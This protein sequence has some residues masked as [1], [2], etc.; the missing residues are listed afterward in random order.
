ME[1]DGDDDN[2]D[3]PAAVDKK[4]RRHDV[5]LGRGRTIQ[6]HPGNVYF[7][8]FL[9]QYCDSYDEAPRNQRRKMASELTHAFSAKDIRFLEQTKNGE[10]IESTLENA[11]NKIGQV[12]RN[13]RKKK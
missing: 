3:I 9:K 1:A 12:F 7:R 5:I 8:K 11:E 10:W 4:P 13:L 6:S 2:D